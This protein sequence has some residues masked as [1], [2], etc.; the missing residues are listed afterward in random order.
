M[1][2]LGNIAPPTHLSN[3]FL[4]AEGRFDRVWDQRDR[5][6]VR[7][8]NLASRGLMPGGIGIFDHDL[9]EKELFF[10][11]ECEILYTK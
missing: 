4:R 1:C 2:L 8:G 5:F 10:S 7:E 6:N 11:V 3:F 9:E